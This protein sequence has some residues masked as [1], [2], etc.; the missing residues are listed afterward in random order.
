MRRQP[1]GGAVVQDRAVHLAPAP[2]QQ[3]RDSPAHDRLGG[4]RL[5]APEGDEGRA[6]GLVADLGAVDQGQ[7]PG[8]HAPHGHRVAR[9]DREHHGARQAR[10]QL[11]LGAVGEDQP[12]DLASGGERVLLHR[13]FRLRQGAGIPDRVVL[14]RGRTGGEEQGREAGRPEAERG[15]ACRHGCRSFAPADG[16]L[17]RDI[18]ISVPD[19]KSLKDL[20]ETRCA[21][22]QASGIPTPSV[23]FS[24]ASRPRPCRSILA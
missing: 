17:D 22:A 21:T 18:P 12:V 8:A 6:G 23:G 2:V 14:R 16:R 5:R 11:H 15:C 10:R 20:D 4:G 3:G 1:Q 13:P 9:P 19:G 7:R 24:D